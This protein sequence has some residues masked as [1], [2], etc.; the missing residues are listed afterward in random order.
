M[1]SIVFEYTWKQSRCH[2]CFKYVYTVGIRT[3]NSVGTGV[4]VTDNK[5]ILTCYHEIGNV[6]D[7]TIY[8]DLE[9]YFPEDKVIRIAEVVESYCNPNLDIAFLKLKQGEEIP[10]QT[11]VAMLNENVSYGH[12]FASLD[13]RKVQQYERLI[14]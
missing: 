10:D 5:L 12:E 4:I 14:L 7:E 1:N 13:Y 9:V 6:E 2:Q 11:A 3:D 8:Q